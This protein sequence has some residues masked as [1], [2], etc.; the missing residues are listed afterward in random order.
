M[1]LIKLLHDK[2][3][4]KGINVLYDIVKESKFWWNGIYDD[5]KNYHTILLKTFY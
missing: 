5:I 2:L 3:Y 4:H 1:N